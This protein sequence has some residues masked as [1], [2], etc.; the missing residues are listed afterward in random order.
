[1]ANVRSW[2]NNYGAKG[3]EGAWM[4]SAVRA[5]ETLCFGEVGSG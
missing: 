1:M 4:E 2:F 5:V 3:R